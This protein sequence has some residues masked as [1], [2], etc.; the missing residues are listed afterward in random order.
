MMCRA[1]SEA[2]NCRV[3]RRMIE[4]EADVLTCA[5]RKALTLADGSRERGFY[6]HEDLANGVTRTHFSTTMDSL[7]WFAGY[8]SRN[9]AAQNDV[10]GRNTLLKRCFVNETGLDG[11][12][13]GAIDWKG[14]D[15]SVIHSSLKKMGLTLT[16]AKRNVPAIVIEPEVPG[17]EWTYLSVSD[18]EEVW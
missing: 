4:I 11:L 9:A 8:I 16:T 7:A 3:T 6:D 15:P 1:L 10:P 17:Q 12:F 2:F 18:E 5:N 14:L 13:V